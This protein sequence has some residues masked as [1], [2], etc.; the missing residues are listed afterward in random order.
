M[1]TI[2]DTD[3]GERT[4]AAFTQLTPMGRGKYGQLFRAAD[5]I[6]GNFF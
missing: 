1:N 4:L 2:S 3:W 5:P 6:T